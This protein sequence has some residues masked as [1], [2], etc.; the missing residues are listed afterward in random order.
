MKENSENISPEWKVIEQ[1]FTYFFLKYNFYN[2]VMI[3]LL[4]YAGVTSFSI[5][6]ETKKVTVI[7]RV[8]PLGVLT[9]ISKVKNAQFWPSPASSSSSSSP[10]PLPSPRVTTLMSPRVSLTR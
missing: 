9:S 4:V 6:L 8:T 7:G 3:I 1:D 10:S 2:I 5:D